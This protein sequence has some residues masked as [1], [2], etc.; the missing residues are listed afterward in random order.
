MALSVAE[1]ELIKVVIRGAIAGVRLKN[2]HTDIK[3]QVEELL[4]SPEFDDATDA[5]KWEAQQALFD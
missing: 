4:S 2:K 5:E 3:Q 1:V